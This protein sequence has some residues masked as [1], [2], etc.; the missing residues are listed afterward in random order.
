MAMVSSAKVKNWGSCFVHTVKPVCTNRK[1]CSAVA[2]PLV[3]PSRVW[4]G[5]ERIGDVRPVSQVRRDSVRPDATP[6]LVHQVVHALVDEDGC[7]CMHV[8]DGS[9][10]RVSASPFLCTIHRHRHKYAFNSAQVA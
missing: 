10:Q 3:V 2:R 9:Q 7:A 4:V 6:S 1:R 5:H 8:W